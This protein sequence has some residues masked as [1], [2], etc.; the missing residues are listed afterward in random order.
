MVK[1]PRSATRIYFLKEPR[2]DSLIVTRFAQG[3]RNFGRA[4]LAPAFLP[5]LCFAHTPINAHG[6]GSNECFSANANRRLYWK[7]SYVALDG[8]TRLMR[9]IATFFRS[10]SPDI[11]G[12]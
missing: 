4:D 2:H 9:N 11:I 3:E 12:D 1:E 6:S 8:W 7:N 10:I 5:G